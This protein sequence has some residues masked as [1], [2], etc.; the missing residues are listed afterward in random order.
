[1]SG[2]ALTREQIEE[3]REHLNCI[4]GLPRS[5]RDINKLCDMARE[6]LGK[7][8]GFVM[9]PREPS[10]AM[11]DKGEFA[12]SEW[13]NDNAPIGQRRYRDPA[14]AVYKAML[15]AAEADGDGE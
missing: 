8:D 15:K 10:E 11:L 3:W 9:V 4:F 7:K 2:D 14:E 1:M 12:N 5:L 13:L 6:S